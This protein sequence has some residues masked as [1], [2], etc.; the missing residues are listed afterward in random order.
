MGTLG[1]ETDIAMSLA[2]FF[3]IFFDDEGASILA[4]GTAVGLGE[5]AKPVISARSLF[6]SSMSS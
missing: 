4:R 5:A 2:F 3:Q 6:K 1:N